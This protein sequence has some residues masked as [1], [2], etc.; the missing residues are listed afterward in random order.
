MLAVR[1]A[2]AAAYGLAPR[3]AIPLPEAAFLRTTS[4]K[5]MR[6]ALR[7]AFLRGEHARACAALDLALDG[8]SEFALPDFLAAPTWVARPPP[9]PLPIASPAATSP[10]AASPTAASPAA[11]SSVAAEV[12]VP[13]LVAA[14]ARSS[15]T[16]PRVLLLAPPAL[17]EALTAELRLVADVD[18]SSRLAGWREWR[19]KLFKLRPTHVIH[20]QLLTTTAETPSR[21]AAASEASGGCDVAA[22]VEASEACASLL[23]LARA[24]HSWLCG[25]V[26]GSGNGSGSGSGHGSSRPAAHRPTLLCVRY[27]ASTS[28]AGALSYEAGG[29]ALATSLCK[30]LAAELG[31]P[32][33]AQHGA[34]GR[35]TTVHVPREATAEAIGAS[36]RA[37]LAVECGLD[38]DVDYDG[39][40]CRRVQRYR[41]VGAQ[42][43]SSQ[44]QN[45]MPSE[46]EVDE[47]TG[48]ARGRPPPQAVPQV[49]PQAVLQPRCAYVVS[50]GLGALGEAVVRLLL[51]EEAS[52]GCSV[53]IVGRRGVEAGA[54]RLKQLGWAG[55][56]VAY[57]SIELGADYAGLHAALAEHLRRSGHALRAVFHL[58]GSYVRHPLV[59]SDAGALAEAIRPKVWGAVHLHRAAAE[60][61]ERPAFVHFGSVA[62]VYAGTGLGAYSAANAFLRWFASWQRQA[63]GLDARTLE[64]ASWTGLGISAR[65]ETL[66]MASW[67]TPLSLEVGLRALRRLIEQPAARALPSVLVGVDWRDAEV[68]CLFSDGPVGLST[69]CLFYPPEVCPERALCAGRIPLCVPT[70]PRT[71][72]GVVD[73]EAL[74]T[75][76]LREL[77]GKPLLLAT[78][79]TDADAD[80]DADGARLSTSAGVLE[81]VLETVTA[82]CGFPADADGDLFDAG[83]SSLTA[84]KL[85]GALQRRLGLELPQ[86]ST[87]CC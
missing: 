22:V 66:G 85:R 52:E 53:L 40:G 17:L 57:A 60:L 44:L 18:G 1:S 68:G 25:S 87:V 59:D 39:D 4:G 15:A 21:A 12:T 77:L 84:A 14:T 79:S 69:S 82:T 86:V 36:L 49:V 56:R 35:V 31:A 83:L 76:P 71:S 65:D 7:A 33:D 70:L 73:L 10:A 27:N 30:A 29:A 9:P 13:E 2:V 28:S 62:A 45:A 64:W 63:S 38:M 61:G 8:A 67:L 50:G 78:D 34:L 81:L 75:R 43:Q 55:G 42:L 6:G 72:A 26:S 54:E 51:A 23:D 32:R 3:Y 46:E 24:L 19:T 11:V 16:A 47:A 48:G 37:E 74:R 41:C 20:A 5:I 58:A 80:A